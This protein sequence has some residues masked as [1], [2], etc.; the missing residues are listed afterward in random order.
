MADRPE[1]TS[2]THNT[3]IRFTKYPVE[4][5]VMIAMTRAGKIRTEAPSADNP[6]TCWKLVGVSDNL[7]YCSKTRDSQQASEYLYAI[8]ERTAEEYHD[9]YARKGR[10]TPERVRYERRTVVLDL[11]MHPPYECW[12]SGGTED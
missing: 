7:W 11:E 3:G 8:S 5:L 4:T 6:W 12:D 9:T 2:T 1:E 10:V